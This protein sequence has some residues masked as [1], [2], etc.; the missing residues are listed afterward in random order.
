M[1]T[2]TPIPQQSQDPSLRAADSYAKATLHWPA[3]EYRLEKKGKTPDGKGTV[4][5][6]VYLD[7][8]RKPVPGGGQSRVLHVD[9]QTGKVVKELR[10]Q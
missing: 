8:E 5:W 10:F 3:T 7:D 4:V 1:S 6:C 9:D 2:M